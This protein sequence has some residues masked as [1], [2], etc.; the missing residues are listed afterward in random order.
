[1]GESGDSDDELL[2]AVANAPERA[3]PAPDPTRIAHFRILG[4]LGQGGMGIVFRAEDETLG[5]TVAL[6]VLPP[7][8][9]ADD[10]RRKRLLREARAAASVSHPNIAAVYEVGEA[11]GHVFIAMEHVE[12]RTLREMVAGGALAIPTAIHLA[13]QIARGL[14]KAHAAS[15]VHRDLKPDNV[16]VGDDGHVTILDFGL[17]KLR[18]REAADPAHADT[19]T[20]EGHVLGTPAYTS[21]EQ[22]QGKDVGPATDVF[23]FGVT[24]Y[25]MLT[26]QRPFSGESRA[27]LIVAIARDAPAAPSRRNEE[28]P[29]TL[30]ALVVRCLAKDPGERPADGEALVT[31]LEPLGPPR[32]EIST[33]ARSAKSASA[34]PTEDALTRTP[35]NEPRPRRHLAALV[36]A[37]IAAVAITAIAVRVS[38]TPQTVPSPQA[39]ASAS[40]PAPRATALTDL[41]P[42]P[43]KVPAAAAEYAAAMQALRYNSWGSAHRHMK[44]AVELDPTMTLGHL[45]LSMMSTDDAVEKREE[46]GKAAAARGVLTERDQILLESLEPVLQRTRDDRSEALA[47]LKRAHERYPL[48]VEFLDWLGILGEGEPAASLPWSERAIELDPKDGQAFQ[49]KGYA[50]ALLGRATEARDALEKC[51]TIAVDTADCLTSKLMLEFGEGRCA[52]AEVS[53]RRAADRD[54]TQTGQLLWPM[55]ALG[56]PEAAVAEVLEQSEPLARNQTVR[57]VLTFGTRSQLAEEAGDLAAAEASNRSA[58]KLVASDPA[59]RANYLSNIIFALDLAQVLLEEGGTDEAR[60]VAEDFVARSANRMKS[61]GGGTDDWPLLL[62]LT[63]GKLGLSLEEFERR[64]AAWIDDQL[65]VSRAYPGHVW[66]HA[67]AGAA[68]TPDEARAALAAL[69][70]FLPLTSYQPNFS[71]DGHIGHAYL[72]AGHAAEAVPYLKRAATSCYVGI[73]RM[74]ARLELGQALEATGDTPGACAAYRTVLERWGHAKPRSVTAEKAR[75]R[76]KALRCPG[77]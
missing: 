62:R 31:A 38:Q 30:D 37:V 58:L 65:V 63:V 54:P 3:P 4:R 61:E 41:P 64:R 16:I 68:M 77:N 56:R 22:A 32:P 66:T 42:P 10:E 2:R 48:D 60:M 17:A 25:E 7:G 21:P 40:S 71:P 34:M 11:D 14:A 15:V 28:V 27:E 57:I 23:A 55:I 9:E 73:P 75:E 19:V 43:T 39:S 59:L 5:R 70:R 46:F 51:A 29:A 1:M 47:R 18:A 6:K 8:F 49:N 69:P 52:D 36:A 13:L 67:Y 45:R 50:L 24:L 76:T 53:A 12:G 44:R 26:G 72:L 33:P 35:A 20:A 74:H